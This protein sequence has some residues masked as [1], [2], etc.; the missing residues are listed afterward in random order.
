MKVHGQRLRRADR[1]LPKPSSMP[2]D[3]KYVSRAYLVGLPSCMIV[4]LVMYF[5]D[6]FDLSSVMILSYVVY[7]F[8]KFFYDLI[9]GF[10]L[11]RKIKNPSNE[12]V[13]RELDK[14]QFGMHFFIV[15]FL[16]IFLAPFGL[17]SLLIRY[18]FR[19][20]QAKRMNY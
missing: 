12:A 10:R 15:F 3:R 20:F 9:L 1:R 19:L 2:F 4:L 16:S 14:F 7:P 17:L 6:E 13:A 18:L 8:A 5:A 11:A